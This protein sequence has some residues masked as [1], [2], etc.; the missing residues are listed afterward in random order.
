MSNAEIAKD[1]VVA[2]IN[3]KCFDV[4]GSNYTNS[5]T[6]TYETIYHKVVELN[7]NR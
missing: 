6:T 3:N 2:M 5:I 4:V 1:I 7:S